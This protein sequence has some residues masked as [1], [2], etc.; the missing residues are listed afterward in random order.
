MKLSRL[1]IVE[2][3]Q[4]GQIVR[5][6]T[7]L[8]NAKEARTCQKCYTVSLKRQQYHSLQLFVAGC[9]RNLLPGSAPAFLQ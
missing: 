7:A 5:Q 1:A 9:L 8:I 2:M 6:I 4:I 3:D